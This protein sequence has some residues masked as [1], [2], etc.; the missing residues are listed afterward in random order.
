M[1]GKSG[2]KNLAPY[3]SRNETRHA[4][5]NE[6]LSER[7]RLALPTPRR[8]TSDKQARSEFEPPLCPLFL[9]IDMDMTFP[10]GAPR[11]EKKS[12]R[13]CRRPSLPLH[14]HAHYSSELFLLVDRSLGIAPRIALLG[15]SDFTERER[16]EGQRPAR[17][18]PRPSS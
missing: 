12:S 18:R 9:S 6:R 13:P 7:T 10:L 2:H 4:N 1:R 8:C 16:V 3:P 14:A 15:R 17:P 11:K 5:C